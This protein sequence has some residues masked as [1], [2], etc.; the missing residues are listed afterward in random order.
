MSVVPFSPGSRAVRADWAG[1][2]P[3]RTG[4]AGGRAASWWCWWPRWSPCAARIN[5]DRAD[6][7]ACDGTRVTGVNEFVR[8]VEVD[9]R[10]TR[11]AR[12]DV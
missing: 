5:F 10:D 12:H 1:S 11:G 8:A 4:G 9:P 2:G 7:L 3:G 6:Q